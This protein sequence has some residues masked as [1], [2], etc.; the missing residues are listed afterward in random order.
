MGGKVR[1]SV[2]GRGRTRAR[3]GS[4]STTL[5]FPSLDSLSRILCD[6]NRRLLTIIDRHRPRSLPDL[7][8]LSGRR[9][10]NLSRTLRML[11]RYGILELRRGK[12]GAIAPI[13]LVRTIRLDLK[14]I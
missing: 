5:S 13:V 6:E 3:N 9:A 12:R 10:S 4:G 11:S 14:L 1:L 8:R 7:E 2:G